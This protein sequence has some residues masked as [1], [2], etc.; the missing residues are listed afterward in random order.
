MWP[1]RG[2]LPLVEP[3]AKAGP[4]ILNQF[5]PLP[6]LV[7]GGTWPLLNL[8]HTTELDAGNAWEEEII[9]SPSRVPRLK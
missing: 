8:L 9:Q 2:R 6:H 7:R 1:K 3:D 5:G 4:M